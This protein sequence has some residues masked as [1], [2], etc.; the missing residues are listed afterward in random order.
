METLSLVFGL[1][2]VYQ[3]KH[4]LADYPLQGGYML[5]KFLPGWD[6]FLPLVC[7]AGVHGLFTLGI[8]LVFAPHLWYLCFV[9]A[10]IHFF[11]D[12]FKAGPKYLGRY[13]ALSGTEFKK[14]L[15]TYLHA[16]DDLARDTAKRRLKSNVYFWWSLGLDQTVHHLTHYIIIYAVVMDAVWTC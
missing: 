3:I 11:M 4:F 13:K 15:D 14:V 1:L 9:D 10:V 8:L 12:R 5:K 16:E 6:F 7:H 2:V